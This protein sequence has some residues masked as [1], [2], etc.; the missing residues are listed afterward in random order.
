MSSLFLHLPFSALD[1][2]KKNNVSNTA[3]ISVFVLRFNSN[4]LGLIVPGFSV[5]Q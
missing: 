2:N 1:R 4:F 3:S 5:G